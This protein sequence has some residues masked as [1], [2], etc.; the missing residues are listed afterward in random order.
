VLIRISPDLNVYTLSAPAS[1]APG[2]SIVVS[3]TTR[4]AGQ[5]TAG[6]STTRIYLSLNATFESAAD[7]PLGFRAVPLLTTGATSS[8]STR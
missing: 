4:N 6:A 5:G 2:A 1:A 8:G 3:D 7:T